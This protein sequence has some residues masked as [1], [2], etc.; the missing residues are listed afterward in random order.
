MPIEVPQDGSFAKFTAPTLPVANAPATVTI[1]SDSLKFTSTLPSTSTLASPSPSMVFDVPNSSVSVSNTN[2]FSVA[3]S[4]QTPANSSKIDVKQVVNFTRSPT[5]VGGAKLVGIPV[6]TS[7]A[8]IFK[9]FGVEPNP[10]DPATIIKAVGIDKLGENLIKE[11]NL[12]S[13]PNIPG[14][15]KVSLYLGA[16]PKFIATTLTKNLT[17]VPPFAPGLKINMAMV[18]GAIAIIG[19]LSSGNPSEILKSLLEDLKSQ[20]ASTLKQQANEALKEALDQT[21]ISALE[22][23]LTDIQKT[24]MDLPGKIA[25]AVEDASL[26]VS[27]APPTDTTAAGSLTGNLS[28]SS[29]TAMTNYTTGGNLSLTGISQPLT[30]SSTSGMFPT[31][32][33]ASTS[34]GSFTNTKINFGFSPLSSTTTGGA[35]Q[36]TTPNPPPTG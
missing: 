2:N 21:G 5:L 15:D 11:L 6:P 27:V 33:P 25:G 22:K 24:A 35:T 19:L 28:L 18:G 4:N 36:I 26:N 34:D 20:V 10:A 1:N 13:I 9:A 29:T 17:I 23:Q 32:V 12:K 14:L 16:G 31:T 30:N 3:L 7:T 8:G